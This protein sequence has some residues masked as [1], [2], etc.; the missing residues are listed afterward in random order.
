MVAR[1]LS[2][3]T[4]FSN[5]DWRSS[6]CPPYESSITTWRCLM[7]IREIQNK[8]T[9][10]A[11]IT[12]T[13]LIGTAGWTDGGL[14]ASEALNQCWFR[15]RSSPLVRSWIRRPSWARLNFL[16]STSHSFS[17]FVVWLLNLKWQVNQSKITIEPVS[18]FWFWE[19]ESGDSCKWIL[20]TRCWIYTYRCQNTTLRTRI[21]HHKTI[22]CTF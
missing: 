17:V 18:E 3:G 11:K 13:Y 5:V 8:A 4:Y 16:P 19:H 21:V 7:I 14:R 22:N 20:I 9:T 12:W 10:K 15:F 1:F 6:N 2:T